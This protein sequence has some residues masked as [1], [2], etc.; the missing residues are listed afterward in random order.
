M[1]LI[2]KNIG[3]QL[4]FVASSFTQSIEQYKIYKKL[5]SG[6]SQDDCCVVYDESINSVGVDLAKVDNMVECFCESLT[7]LRDMHK[8]LAKEFVRIDAQ[9]KQTAFDV[10]SIQLVE[11]LNSSILNCAQTK[12]LIDLLGFPSTT[13]WKLLY[14]GQRDGYRA[15]DFHTRCDSKSPTLTIIKSEYGNIFGGYTEIPWF[16]GDFGKKDD[17][18]FIF[19]LVNQYNRS[20]KMPL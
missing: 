1:N 15:N 20:Y 7:N 3:D 17:K 16:Q 10:K 5:T 18:L 11:S 14:S 8:E 2:F 4:S 19:S 9:L 6:H 13:K 12:E